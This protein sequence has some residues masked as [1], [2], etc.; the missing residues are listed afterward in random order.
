MVFNSHSFI[1][2]FLPLCLAGYFLAGRLAGSRAAHVFMTAASAVFVFWGFNIAGIAALAASIIFNYAF[3]RG[4]RISRHGKVLLA[5]AIAVNILILFGLKYAKPISIHLQPFFEAYLY[6][7]VEKYIVIPLGISFYTF[8]QISFL[9]DAYRN[10]V[11]LCGFADYCCYVTFFP[12]IISGPIIRHDQFLFQLKDEER[13]RFNWENFSKG[14]FRFAIGLGKKVLIADVL[15][16]PAN[17][18]FS[19]PSAYTGISAAVGLLAF[20][21]QLYFD[22][23]GYCDMAAGIASMFNFEIPE[24]FDSPYKALNI[25]DFWNRWHITLTQF[26]TRYVYFSL[27]GSRKGTFR[28][29]INIMIIFLISGLWHGSDT[30]K[31]FIVWGLMHGAAMVIYRIGGRQIDRLPK[32]VTRIITFIFVC[33]AWIP[34]RMPDLSSAFLMLKNMFS[35]IAAPLSGD[36]AMAFRLKE[37]AFFE[38]EFPNLAFAAGHP[39]IYCAVFLVFAMILVLFMKNSRQ[40]TEKFVPSVKTLIFAALI[41]GWSLMSLTGVGTFIYAGF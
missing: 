7:F 22:F 1:M 8:Q 9:M 14:L 15:S 36:V 24:N 2:L 16:A 35:S 41:I 17:L 12:K 38:Q 11:P 3:Y 27:G 28:T 6:G 39:W 20:A 5:A 21:L 32:V 31:P 18:V 40:M 34:F 10:E 26:L 25:K 33:I 29:Y 13:I 23:S 4:I 30:F 19:N 37:A